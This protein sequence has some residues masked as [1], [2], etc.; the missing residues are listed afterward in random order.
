MADSD[1]NGGDI[2]AVLRLVTT[3]AGDDGDRQLSLLTYA[4]VIGCRSCGVDREAALRII[5]SIYD[6]D[7]T[8]VPLDDPRVR[9][10]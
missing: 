6:Q 4:L 8:L 7:I 5:G 3:L 2:N 10:S 1:L 9:G